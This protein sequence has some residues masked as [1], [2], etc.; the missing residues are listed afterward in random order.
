MIKQ[1]HHNIKFGDFECFGGSDVVKKSCIAK[2]PPWEVV[3]TPERQMKMRR[4]ISIG[5]SAPIYKNVDEPENF[6]NFNIHFVI[7]FKKVILPTFYQS[8]AIYSPWVWKWI[9]CKTI[10]ISWRKE[11]II[12]LFVTWK[13]WNHEFPN[14][15]ID[16]FKVLQNVF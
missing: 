7:F 11:M 13:K 9:S 1:N 6:I 15:P 8:K 14:S 2:D 4:T 12:N 16:E 10:T 3:V 5:W